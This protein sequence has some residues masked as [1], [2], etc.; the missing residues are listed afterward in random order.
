MGKKLCQA[1]AAVVTVTYP[2]EILNML[3]WTKGEDLSEAK[4]C[5]LHRGAPGDERCI[6]GREIIELERSF[7][8]TGEAKIP[9]HRIRRIE[10]RGRLLFDEKRIRE[11]EIG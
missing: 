3:R 8:V 7:F 2:R 11:K 9:Y 10:Y 5:Y 4:I 6:E 1:Q